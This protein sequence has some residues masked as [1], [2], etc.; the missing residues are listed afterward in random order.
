M[1]LFLDCDTGLLEMDNI[2]K[3][4]VLFWKL[5]ITLLSLKDNSLC[6]QQYTYHIHKAKCIH[7]MNRQPIG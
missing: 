6:R 4:L 2:I 7:L 3:I 1:A 5:P